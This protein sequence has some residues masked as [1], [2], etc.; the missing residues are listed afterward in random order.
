MRRSFIASTILLPMIAAVLLWPAFTGRVAADDGKSGSG[1]TA[2]DGAIAVVDFD[3][4]DTSGE[5]RD[6]RQ[7]HEA[8][9]GAFMTALKS[10]LA[11]RGKTVVSLNC[12]PSP[13]SVTRTPPG[14]LLRAA[15][16]AGADILLVGGI[17]KMST[18]IQWAKADAI[19]TGVE[20]VVLSKLFTFR[21]DTDDA[22]RRAE[23]FIA[24]QLATG[25]PPA[26]GR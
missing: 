25:L 17:H 16:D 21:G 11:A 26:G 13:C 23:S 6:Q 4:R 1:K 8:R 9:L 14:D 24:D 18:L 12:D 19:D 15:R 22:W 5:V 10:D 20:K 3:Y 2:P 7:E